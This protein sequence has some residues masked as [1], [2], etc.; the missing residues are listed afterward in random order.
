MEKKLRKGGRSELVPGK[1]LGGTPYHL[2]GVVVGHKALGFREGEPPNVGN[3]LGH[4]RD[5]LTLGR[6][7]HIKAAVLVNALTTGPEN[8]V[9]LS[10]FRTQDQ[11][12]ESGFLFDLPNGGRNGVLALLKVTLRE[13]PLPVR[14]PNE[15]D[16][17]FAMDGPEHHP[18][19]T[20][21]HLTHASRASG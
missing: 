10:K 8:P 19:G 18:A 5:R 1:E 11:P 21:F 7:H 17:D 14:V 12:R 6:S 2:T 20:S 15:K 16:V 13:S 4:L 9:D 3:S